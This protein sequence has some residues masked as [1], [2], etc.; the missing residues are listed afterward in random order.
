MGRIISQPPRVEGFPT[1]YRC[2]TCGNGMGKT[3]AEAHVPDSHECIKDAE[4][5]RWQQGS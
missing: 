5:R 2:T 4:E 3:Q 1:T